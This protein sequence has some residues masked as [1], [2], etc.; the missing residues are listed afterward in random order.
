[1]V[2]QYTMNAERKDG[3]KDN[4]SKHETKDKRQMTMEGYK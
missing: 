2:S 1:M 3:G 4:S